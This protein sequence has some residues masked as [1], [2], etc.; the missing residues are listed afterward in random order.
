MGLLSASLGLNVSGDSM[1][2]GYI[3][4][5]L[6]KGL[7]TVHVVNELTRD[8]WDQSKY[9]NEHRGQCVKSCLLSAFS[10]EELVKTLADDSMFE[11]VNDTRIKSEIV[12]DVANY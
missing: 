4:S 12:K 9:Y 1:T 5:C 11:Y 10:R 8:D 6:D 7:T 2:K 3:N